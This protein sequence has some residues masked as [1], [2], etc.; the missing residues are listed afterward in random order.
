MKRIVVVVVIVIL[1]GCT[2]EDLMVPDNG[3]YFPKVKQIIGAH[4]LSCHD[5]K[6]TWEGRPV[7]LDEDADISQQYE[8]IK[9]GVAD[10]IS[11]TNR[12]MPQG[13][14]LSA[15]DIDVIVKW[16]DKGGKIAD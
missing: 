14:E 15:E 16:F 2:H 11:P 4:C 6:G 5:S 9:R 7:K 13:G 1:W 10:P 8:A 12:R 3:P